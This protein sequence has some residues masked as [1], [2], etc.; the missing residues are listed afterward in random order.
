MR[1][2][3]LGGMA[4]LCAGV[5]ISLGGSTSAHAATTPGTTDRVSVASDGTQSNGSDNELR[6]VSSDGCVSAGV[7]NATNLVPGDTNGVADVFVHDCATGQTTR[8]SV[9]TD[10][11]QGD[12]SS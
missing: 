8:V 3:L 12:E 1:T 5:L 4:T 11:T 10:G 2:G 9:A 6:D 7:S